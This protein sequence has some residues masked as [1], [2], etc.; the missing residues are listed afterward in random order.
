MVQI[1]HNVDQ[2]TGLQALP[3]NTDLSSGFKKKAP[4]TYAEPNAYDYWFQLV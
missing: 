2:E 3:E 1:L 4:L